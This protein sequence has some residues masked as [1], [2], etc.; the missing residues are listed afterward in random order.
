MGSRILGE[1]SLELALVLALSALALVL[2]V[3]WWRARRR[4]ATGPIDEIELDS[5]EA[6]VLAHGLMGF[7]SIGIGRSRHSYFRGIRDGLERAG[8]PTFSPSVSPL[9]SVPERAEQLA[10]F[11][12]TLPFED[13]ILIGHSMGG[14]DAR[15]A[16]TKLGMNRSVRTLITIGTPHRGSPLADLADTRPARALRGIAARFGLRSDAIDWLT[17]TNLEAFNRDIPDSPGVRYFSVVGKTMLRDLWRNPLLLGSS[18]FL[19]RGVDNDGIVTVE[20]QQ[21]GEVL[22]EINTDHFGQIGWSFRSKASALY[23]QLIRR[24][25]GMPL[26]K[27]HSENDDDALAS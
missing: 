13:I 6:V 17:T 9:G 11:I 8:I 26:A 24:A 21:W 1:M 7:E 23:L 20:S 3:W 27:D 4:S 5:T 2:A 10:E 14:L 12:D 19:R 16:I 18:L 15:Y 25:K 22:S